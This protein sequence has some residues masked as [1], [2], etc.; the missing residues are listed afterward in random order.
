MAVR[1]V[2]SFTLD[3]QS[4]DGS[5]IGRE[6]LSATLT[7]FILDAE[8][9]RQTRVAFL[10]GLPGVGKTALAQEVLQQ[11]SAQSWLFSRKYDQYLNAAP[12]SF[13]VSA[14]EDLTARF[15]KMPNAEQEALRRR[16][17]D[18]VSPNGQLLI[19][20]CAK[21]GPVLGIQPDLIE[22][23]PLENQIRL[24]LVL[25]KFIAAL[26][27]LQR[28]I[29]L[30]IDDLQWADPTTRRIL[31]DLVVDPSVSN[32]VVLVSFRPGNRETAAELLRAVKINGNATIEIEVEGLSR[33][34]IRT[35]LLRSVALSKSS[36]DILSQHIRDVTQGIPLAVINIVNLLIE[37]GVLRKD[38]DGETWSLVSEDVAALLGETGVIDLMRERLSVLAPG[39]LDVLTAAASVGDTFDLSLLEKLTGLGFDD[40]RERIATLVDKHILV[41]SDTSDEDFENDRN[42]LHFQHDTMQQAA[43]EFRTAEA[44]DPARLQLVAAREFAMRFEETG[45]TDWL[46]RAATLFEGVP[47]VSTDPAEAQSGAY[48]CRLAARRALDS[49]G[50]AMGLRFARAGL[51]GTPPDAWRTDYKTT[52]SAHLVAA[53]AAYLCND[54]DALETHALEAA[55]KAIHAVD[56]AAANRIRLQ[57]RVSAMRYD[58]ALDIAVEMLSRLDARLPRTVGKAQVVLG[59]VRTTLALRGSTPESLFN[60][61]TMSDPRAEMEL[62][63]LM[64]ASSA[65]YFAQPNLFAL[66]IFRMVRLSL[67]AGNS[68]NS[69]FAWVCFG[70]VQCSVIGNV[71]LGYDYGVLA[72]RL[73]EQ[74]GAENL[75]ARVHMLF[76][77]FV[78]PWSESRLAIE[79]HLLQGERAGFA[80]GDLEFATYCMWHRCNDAF[81]SGAPLEQVRQT[82]AECLVVCRGHHQ[83]KVVFLLE[84]MLEFIG[85]ATSATADLPDD[86]A[87]DAYCIERKDFTA[88]CYVKLFQMLRHVIAGE[89][90]AALAAARSIDQQFDSLQGQFYVPYYVVLRALAAATSEGR[91][92]GIGKR[93]KLVQASLRQIRAWVRKGAT[94]VAPLESIVR[95]YSSLAAGRD[96]AA[97]KWFDRVLSSDYSQ[98]APLPF[99]FIAAQELSR[100][101]RGLGLHRPSE[102]SAEEATRLAGEWGCVRRSTAAAS[103]DDLQSPTRQVDASL[104]DLATVAAK[105]IFN[106]VGGTRFDIIFMDKIRQ[107]RLVRVQQDE[108]DVLTPDMEVKDL[109]D[110]TRALVE[111]VSLSSDGRLMRDESKAMCLLLPQADLAR[112]YLIVTCD[113]GMLRR[114]PSRQLAV[115]CG[116]LVACLRQEFIERRLNEAEARSVDLMTAYGRFIPSYLLREL[117]HR[118]ITELHVGDSASRQ[119]TVMFCD[120]RGATG[121]MEQIGPQ[122]SMALFNELFTAI[123]SEVLRGGG[124]IDNFIGDAV[125]ALFGSQADIALRTAIEVA[126]TLNRLKDSMQSRGLPAPSSGLGISTGDVVFGVVGGLNQ[127]RVGAIGDTLNLAAR[128]ES[129]TKRYETSVLIAQ[130]TFDALQA[131]GAFGLRQ[132][133]HVTVVGRKDPVRLY[134]V[135]DALEPLRAQRITAMLPTFQRGL[136][137]FYAQDFETAVDIF[138]ACATSM[139]EDFP[140][141]MFL[142]RATRNMSDGVAEG[143]NGVHN[144]RSK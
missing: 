10:S 4:R 63:T 81:W 52:F 142:R 139:P 141:R 58:E 38:A 43:R 86:R 126:H 17:V 105:R 24:S 131:P 46:F 45:S 94:D 68:A 37:K 130:Q 59:L 78:R 55:G 112:V 23:A 16:L 32:L 96:L 120:M 119:M 8:A 70:L 91:R 50:P 60:L 51:R 116:P 135:I 107:V 103:T 109:D 14:L 11:T 88:F 80:T 31:A 73:L 1:A 33:D 101:Q 123:E 2:K 6:A 39:L 3:P 83:S 57:Q 9:G 18:A 136:T 85:W 108:S 35:L 67:V 41:C 99:A 7:Q 71:K 129:L 128:V 75:R 44:P 87:H 29:I 74:F 97:M 30:H 42:V 25:R 114:V 82:V 100:M 34:D 48:W 26:P 106:M 27:D 28:R 143:W 127:I 104:D 125:L 134:E 140:T 22:L 115:A 110:A 12:A 65:A 53:E 56:W 138:Q 121:I 40:L 122:D 137:A 15:Q 79:S 76:N 72:L 5:L 111:D 47:E 95:A 117:G 102:H 124:F 69:A 93:R 113:A 84:M 132:V 90:E 19:N 36:A 62:E 133:D 98:G 77:V 64:L 21:I 144:L 49:G 54:L 20:L 13:F 89:T 66:I 92:G 118:D 61:P